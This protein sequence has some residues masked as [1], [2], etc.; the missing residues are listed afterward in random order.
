[1]KKT[2]KKY[3]WTAALVFVFGMLF[4]PGLLTVKRAEAATQG[5]QFKYDSVA[6]PDGS[7]IELTTNVSTLSVETK[8]STE[9]LP[10]S[11]TVQFISSEESVIG[12]ENTETKGM[13]RLKRNGPG[14][15]TITAFITER[16]DTGEERRYQID[17]LVKVDLE[18]KPDNFVNI[19][20]VNHKVLKL[21]TA[22][23]KNKT[24]R[25]DLR[26]RDNSLIKNDLVEWTS[27]NE[28]VATVDK[29]GNVTA[30][31]AGQAVITVETR[32]AAGGTGVVGAA[33][34]RE[35]AKVIVA[36]YGSFTPDVKPEPDYKD[37]VSKIEEKKITDDQ[38]TVYVNSRSAENL[39]WVVSQLLFDA[40]GKPITDKSGKQKEKV[41][42]DDSDV[43]KYNVNRF[44]GSVNFTS[45][46]VGTYVI[47]A[48][49]AEEYKGN[50]LVPSFEA[51][52]KVFPAL[53]KTR[54][55]MNVG[56]SYDIVAN[57][58]I[59][60]PEAF[61]FF[62]SNPEVVQVDKKTGILTA[63]NSA[64]KTP[65]TI[66]LT[67]N[68]AG[69]FGEDLK[70]EDIP[71][72]EVTVI[73]GIH[74]NFEDV[75][76]LKGGTVALKLS[77]T[78]E[79]A[80]VKWTSSDPK[81]AKVDE[82]GVVTGVAE[83]SVTITASQTIDGVVKKAS[84]N[85]HVKVIRDPVVVSKV[86]I[87]P[88][89]ATLEI[90]ERKTFLAK[91]DPQNADAEAVDLKW[92]S[93]DESIVKI[94]AV[95]TD[96]YTATVQGVSAGTAVI[97]VI[98]KNNIV[99]G[100]CKITV[101]PPVQPVTGITL[102]ESD[103][104]GRIGQTVQLQATVNPNNATNPKI[105]WKSLD[106]KVATVSANGLV[107][108]KGSGSTYITCTSA[109]NPE[110]QAYCSVKVLT[111]VSGVA[112][113]V[114]SKEMYVGE[115]YRLSYV[116]SPANASTPSV[117][118][119]STNSAVVTVDATGMLT[120]RG[121]GQ[122]EIIIKTVDGS[123]MDLCTIV[124]KQKPTGVK[125][126]VS[127]LTLN[128]GEFFYLDAILTPA[129]AT[130]E[131]LVWEIVDKNIATL[132]SNGRVEAKSAGKTIIM[133]KTDNGS[134]SYCNLTV[135]EAVTKLELSPNKLSIDV[136]DKVTLTPKFT[137]EKASNTNV[138]WSSSDESVAT[139]N[140]HG[141]VTGVKGGLAVIQCQSDDG[142]YN[143]FC[144]VE[145]DEKVAEIVITPEQYKL[146]LGK[147]YLLKAEISNSTALNKGVEW[148]SSDEDIVTVDKNGRIKGISLGYATITAVAQDGS[149]AEATCE[150]RVVTEVSSMT[151]N[152]T[153]LTLIQG[154][155]HQLEA[156]ILPENATYNTPSWES[157][158]E[159]IA[160]VD[161][162]GMVTALS[163]GSVWITA[164]ARDESGRYCKCYVTVIAPVPATN[165]TTMVSEIVLAPGERKTVVA[166]STPAN[167]TDSM[168]WT[169][170]D[171]SVARVNAVT[172]EITAVSPGNTSVIV[173]MDSG[174]KAVVNV[175]V[176]GLS[177]TS[178]LMDYYSTGPQ[179]YVEG[180]TE[181][182]RWYSSN[183][184]VV[185]VSANGSLT[186]RGSGT[187]T[188]EARVNGRTLTC[189]VR[190]VAP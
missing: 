165:V 107:T 19:D 2:L 7:V 118:W 175:I 166:K 153:A 170:T 94:E 98:N 28:Q 76:I 32:T 45:V 177:R 34:L 121:I 48:Y 167:T 163:P 180:T 72:I 113:D 79:L 14:Y 22:D 183:R 91:V 97:T 189:T 157:E 125:I 108:F 36:P 103:L 10:A 11:A 77:L 9:G 104:V 128:V 16:D 49:V 26:Y 90:E 30:V 89:S 179:L 47:R 74:L 136:G 168:T 57:S 155:T 17:C 135:L 65:V 162:N 172:G 111:S 67:Y 64:P 174:K 56:D 188:V 133:V 127:D 142:G 15:S 78:D 93:S 3:K 100:F 41:L 18:I 38:F 123:Y 176:V 66:T 58:N 35:S 42:D 99:V 13:V 173:M 53:K 25:I 95:T 4:L 146:G 24:K 37:F 185:E 52:V 151:M 27:S 126:S 120:A 159:K 116:V 71:T 63:L 137:P 124:V 154:Q 171:E 96:S 50:E 117:T 140:Q 119:S 6:Y 73:D 161:D 44:S 55:V 186:S 114:K 70:K 81:I 8:E 62:S 109:S 106:P 122:A 61:L 43:L 150:I 83:G 129:N 115:N 141:E 190:V 1:M 87:N 82:D 178:V 68:N 51:T 102:S 138:I 181:K 54:L 40:D 130:K 105:T 160:L 59:P 33:P 148:F 86:T 187:A 31:G 23:E 152:T 147:T 145:V 21:D 101:K 169:S 158:D 92:V 88:S 110:V 85:V 132:S 80:A 184:R 143:A 156:T 149:D 39:Y 182:V 139:V 112:L 12:L 46:K 75:T 84:C 29:E 144:V 20:Y 164:K 60:F 5:F 134:T 69:L 131:G